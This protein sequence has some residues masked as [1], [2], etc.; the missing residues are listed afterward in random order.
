MEQAWK[1]LRGIILLHGFFI[2]THEYYIKQKQTIKAGDMS[3]NDWRRLPDSAGIKREGAVPFGQK[4]AG[5]E[6]RVL[7]SLPGVRHRWGICIIPLACLLHKMPGNRTGGSGESNCCEMR[8]PPGW[9]VSQHNQYH[10]LNVF[11]KKCKEK[12][13]VHDVN[14][15]TIASI[16]TFSS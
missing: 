6:L 12:I 11:D 4:R 16:S 3:F 9:G 2:T 15:V 7:H 14:N 10:L 8:W 1:G 5:G 13:Q